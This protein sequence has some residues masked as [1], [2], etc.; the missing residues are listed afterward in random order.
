MLALSDDLY[1][2]CRSVDYVE[3]GVGKVHRDLPGVQGFGDAVPETDANPFG[4]NHRP[5]G[6][7]PQARP[8]VRHCVES[9]Q[10][11]VL[12]SGWPSLGANGAAPASCF[13]GISF[14]RPLGS[15]STLRTSV[16]QAFDENGDGLVLRGHHF[17]WDQHDGKSPHLPEEMAGELISMVL[18][19]YQQERGQRP[20]RVVVHK[21]SRFEPE[22]RAGLRM[23]CLGIGRSSAVVMCNKRSPLAASREVS[24][25]L[26][27]TA[28]TV[29]DISYLYTSGYLP[30]RDGILTA[31]FRPR[32]RL[33][34]MWAIR[35]NVSCCGKSWY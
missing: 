31:T 23:P 9:L 11:P 14:Y 22:E 6:F 19:R 17:D 4:S 27:G 29:G 12:Q 30:A 2:K 32:F 21:T 5:H 33:P 7:H 3:S 16:V 28:F 15:T 1:R 26:R 25:P 18:D 20:Q 13:I 35:P 10:R 24:P 8:Q 34:V